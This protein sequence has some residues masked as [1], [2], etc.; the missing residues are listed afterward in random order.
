M[1]PVNF[2]IQLKV[3]RSCQLIENPYMRIKE[4]ALELGFED[5]LYF[6]RVFTKV[7]GISPL[8]FRKTVLGI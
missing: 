8:S 6:S 5:P 7:M 3:Q 4:I 2:F 1:S